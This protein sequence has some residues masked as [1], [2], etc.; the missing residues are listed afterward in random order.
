MTIFLLITFFSFVAFLLHYFLI[1]SQCS[2][3]DDEITSL[4]NLLTSI[5]FSISLP[6]THRLY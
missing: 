3:Y 2:Y 4:S 5:Y 1:H 6:P